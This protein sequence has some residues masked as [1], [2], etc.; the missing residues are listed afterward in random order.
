[1]MNIQ[2]AIAHIIN[3]ND[4]TEDEAYTIMSAIMSGQCTQAQIV[5]DMLLR[6]AIL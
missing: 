5:L 3:D 4:L 2:N 1:M 6:Y